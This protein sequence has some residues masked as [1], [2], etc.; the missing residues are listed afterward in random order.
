MPTLESGTFFFPIDGACHR[1]GADETAFA[2]REASFGV[3]IFGTWSDPADDERNTAWVRDYDNALRPFARGGGYVNFSS[4]DEQGRVPETYGGN[5][6]R[7]AQLKHRYDPENIFRLN[8]NV[9]P[10]EA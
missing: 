10:V 9:V 5:H 2:F 1:V 3:G 7:L 6:V 4:G 8:Q